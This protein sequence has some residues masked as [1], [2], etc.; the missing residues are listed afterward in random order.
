MNNDLKLDE[1]VIKDETVK[2][3]AAINKEAQTVLKTWIYHRLEAQ[4]TTDHCYD[5]GIE[6]VSKREFSTAFSAKQTQGS[7]RMSTFSNP[8]D[9]QVDDTGNSRLQPRFSSRVNIERST[10]DRVSVMNS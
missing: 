9:T 2:A 6:I 1:A 10:I 5:R 3:M 4:A 8:E 7:F